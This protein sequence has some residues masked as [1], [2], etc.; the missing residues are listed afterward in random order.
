MLFTKESSA[1]LDFE[2]QSEK[3]YHLEQMAWYFKNFNSSLKE[4]LFDFKRFTEHARQLEELIN[5]I[6]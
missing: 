3:K 1:L 4:A 5:E 6:E 2:Q